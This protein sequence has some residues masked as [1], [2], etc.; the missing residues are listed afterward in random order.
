MKVREK[1]K[2]TKADDKYP[3]RKTHEIDYWKGNF[4]TGDFNWYFKEKN[5]EEEEFDFDF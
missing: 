5:K 2:P 4:I 3:P 1:Q